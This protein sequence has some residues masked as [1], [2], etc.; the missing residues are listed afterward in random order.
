MFKKK[1]D[2]NNIVINNKQDDLKKGVF[3]N[4]KVINSFLSASLILIGSS[5]LPVNVSNTHFDKGIIFTDNNAMAAEN[6]ADKILNSVKNKVANDTRITLFD[7]KVINTKSGLVAQ[8]KVLE[9]SQRQEVIK[10]LSTLGKVK[11]NIEVFP[12]AETGEL[13]YGVANLPVMQIRDKGKHSSQ[14]ITQGLF[15]MTMKIIGGHPKK[16]DWVLVSMNDDKYVGWVRRPDIWFVNKKE[17]DSWN[18]QEKIILTDPTV[19]VLNSANKNDKSE[20]KLYMSTRLNL[21]GESGD[22]YEVKLPGGNKHYSNHNT[23]IAKSSAR[24]IGKNLTPFN[25]KGQD[26]VVKAKMLLSAPYLWGG[27]S[28]MMND[29]SGYTQLLYKVNGYIIPRDADQQQ[30]FSKPVASRNDLKVGDLVFFAENKGKSATHVGM[31]IGDKKFIHSSVGYGGVA[32]TSFD[33]K[34]SLFNSWYIDNY[35]TAGRILK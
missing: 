35:L 1:S 19:Q 14:L 18:N 12:F 15:G 29:C 33:P 25:I 20:L 32:I 23:Y 5:I 2:N 26:L 3:K 11:N 34:D 22:Y 24:V 8:G 27:S 9:E 17:F 16:D 30:F 7:V 6:P 31:Y 21:V 4:N 13:S 10:E 28:P